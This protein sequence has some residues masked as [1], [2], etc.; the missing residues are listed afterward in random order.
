FA[1]AGRDR[2]VRI[3]VGCLRTHVV[4]HVLRSPAPRAQ[5]AFSALTA[6]S[7][8]AISF[9]GETFSAFFSCSAVR[10]WGACQLRESPSS[11]LQVAH[12]SIPCLLKKRVRRKKSRLCTSPRAG[13][14]RK[15]AE[16]AQI[17]FRKIRFFGS[18]RARH[19]SRERPPVGWR[20]IAA[21][22]AASSA[23]SA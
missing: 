7:A 16:Y 3:G 23:P 4:A 18:Q 20:S 17:F 6:C 14:Q 2:V 12:A 9:G 22:A 8:V 10:V 13:R 21:S 1:L 15:N 11:Q 5:R 19:V